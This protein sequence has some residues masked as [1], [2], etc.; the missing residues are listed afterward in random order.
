MIKQSE[1]GKFWKK[2]VLKSHLKHSQQHSYYL[3]YELIAII[4]DESD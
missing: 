2:I 3:K 4:R 1:I